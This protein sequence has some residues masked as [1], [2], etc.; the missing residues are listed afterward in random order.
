MTFIEILG[1]VGSF[2]LTICGLPQLWTTFAKK[3][4]RGLSVYMSIFWCAGCLCMLVVSI[5][6][7]FPVALI[8]NYILNALCAGAL[9]VGYFKYRG[10]K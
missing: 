3:D 1:W 10:Q 6:H 7:R 5:Y 9:I 4:V 2:F 8:T